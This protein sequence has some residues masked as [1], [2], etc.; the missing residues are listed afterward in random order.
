MR[1]LLEERTDIRP[2]H[3]VNEGGGERLRLSDGRE[4][5]SLSVGEK[6]T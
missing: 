6:G 3:S 4:M 1:W 5:L 2:T